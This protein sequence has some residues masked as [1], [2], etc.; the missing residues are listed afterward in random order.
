MRLSRKYIRFNGKA[1]EKLSE[2]LD[3]LPVY[4]FKIV[5]AS[6]QP[7]KNI[8]LKYSV[9]S[10]NSQPLY[11]LSIE[12]TAKI[13]TSYLEKIVIRTDSNI[14]REFIIPVHGNIQ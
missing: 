13:A 11:R 8:R 9:E 4:P 12:N 3:I 5:N 14:R 10:R 7:G 2:Q 1:G 6:A